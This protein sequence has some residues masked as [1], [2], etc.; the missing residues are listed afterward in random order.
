VQGRTKGWLFVKKDGKTRAQI[1][2]YNSSFLHYLELAKDQRPEL[3]SAGTL[4]H[5]FS[6]VITSQVPPKRHGS[7]HDGKGGLHG[8]EPHQPMENEG[9]SEGNRSGPHDGANLHQL[10]GCHSC[11][12]YVLGAAVSTAPR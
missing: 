10:A 6:L 12:D 7:G 8:G 2:D 9:G 4:M 5:M 1:R 3:F 11:H